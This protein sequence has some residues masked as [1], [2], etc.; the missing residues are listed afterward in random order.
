MLL[1]RHCG[2]QSK[3]IPFRVISQGKKIMHVQTKAMVLSL[4]AGAA[5][6]PLAANAQ[7]PNMINKEKE[8]IRHAE[9]AHNEIRRE[10]N[11][12]HDKELHAA[13]VDASL[14]HHDAVL[15]RDK[16]L[17]AERAAHSAANSARHDENIIKDKE[18]HAARVDASIAH[19]E[20]VVAKDKSL[21][22]Q[23]GAAAA[24]GVK[25]KEH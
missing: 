2:N 18:L 11:I 16:A 22:A 15:A 24:T 13:R 17:A 7:S 14:E 9:Q 10:A 4:L 1:T 25:R 3:T 19:H 20:A 21:A 23:R 5:I 12:E 6:A 8:A